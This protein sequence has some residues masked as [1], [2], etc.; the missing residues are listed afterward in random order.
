M[1]HLV[2]LLFRLQNLKRGSL[3]HF[4]DAIYSITEF[5]RKMYVLSVKVLSPYSDKW[6]NEPLSMK[7]RFGLTSPTF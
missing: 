2:K 5:K 6:V 3:K 7:S 4:A 1:S